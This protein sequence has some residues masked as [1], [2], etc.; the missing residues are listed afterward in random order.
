MRLTGKKIL[1]VLTI[2]LT[3]IGSTASYH[4]YKLW[5]LQKPQA[6]LNDDGHVVLNGELSSELLKKLKI[7]EENINFEGRRLLVRSAGGRIVVGIAIGQVVHKY[8]MDVEVHE[9]CVSAC[10]NYI[11]TA[12]NHKYVRHN[13]GLIF[14]GGMLQHNMKGKHAEPSQWGGVNHEASVLPYSEK[15]K[16]ELVEYSDLEYDQLGGFDNEL[17]METHFFEMIGVNQFITV[18]GQLGEYASKY[19][20]DHI[21]F[22]YTVN[23]LKKFGVDNVSFLGE[24]RWRPHTNPYNNSP[25]WV[26]VDANILKRMP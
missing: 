21:G 23:D 24:G 1:S 10:A 12:G 26:K 5:K 16:L 6:Y 15:E 2:I 3:L 4:F 14:H 17:A 9:F 7:L 19:S 22:H 13:S 8:N 20:S 11:F 25:Y 18:Y